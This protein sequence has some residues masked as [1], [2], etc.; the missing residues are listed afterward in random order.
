MKFM[1]CKDCILLSQCPSG[2]RCVGLTEDFARYCPVGKTK[3]EDK[4]DE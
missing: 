2:Q 3:M 1:K 4:E